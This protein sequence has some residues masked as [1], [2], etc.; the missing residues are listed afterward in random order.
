MAEDV[1]IGEENI[2]GN[3]HS[4]TVGILRARRAGEI[5][6]TMLEGAARPTMTSD[7]VLKSEPGSCQ[8]VLSMRGPINAN[9]M[10]ILMA[11]RGPSDQKDSI[12]A[13]DRGNSAMGSGAERAVRGLGVALVR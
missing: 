13:S 2:G 4:N 9:I 3:W 7:A 5:V 1:N 8:K 11:G 10:E 6:P 12:G